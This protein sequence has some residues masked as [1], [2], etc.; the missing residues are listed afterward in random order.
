MFPQPNFILK[1]L[2]GFVSESR[3]EGIW[4]E[5]I[6]V[7]GKKGESFNLTGRMFLAER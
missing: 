3:W 1:F 6:E 4:A 7:E 2:L 5:G